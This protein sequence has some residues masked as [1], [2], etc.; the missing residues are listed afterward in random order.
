MG[1]NEPRRMAFT[2]GGSYTKL[3]HFAFVAKWGLGWQPTMRGRP[4]IAK[5]QDVTTW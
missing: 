3:I 2:Q 1:I 5:N 4:I